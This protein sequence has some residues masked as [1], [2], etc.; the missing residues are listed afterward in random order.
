MATSDSCYLQRLSEPLLALIAS[1]SSWIEQ[2]DIL[3]F[4]CRKMSHALSLPAAQI[5]T[6]NVYVRTQG[7]IFRED[8]PCFRDLAN[9]CSN[10]RRAWVKHR[11]ASVLDHV[12]A[13]LPESLVQLSVH[14]T[15]CMID[16]QFVFAQAW[17][18][19]P[20]LSLLRK[21]EIVTD[22]PLPTD[23]LDLF[24]CHASNLEEIA[25]GSKKKPSVMTRVVWRQIWQGMPRLQ[26][27]MLFGFEAS[28]LLQDACH[29]QVDAW[30]HQVSRE[31]GATYKRAAIQ[32]RAKECLLEDRFLADMRAAL[33]NHEAEEPA[34]LLPRGSTCPRLARISLEL[35]RMTQDMADALYTLLYPSHT[36]HLELKRDGHV[37]R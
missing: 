16:S 8:M 9:L 15:D 32:V 27:L 12:F 20:R 3:R 2:E 1:F 10:V 36:R 23:M 34:S 11:D 31:M 6:P 30:R 24:T 13:A 14:L 28:S 33:G 25:L 7:I 17:T 19:M 29:V 26:S 21:L 4:L 18:S 22:G 5:S 37:K 35:V